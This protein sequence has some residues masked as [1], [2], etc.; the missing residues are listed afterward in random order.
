MVKSPSMVFFP[1]RGPAHLM[2][3]QNQHPRFSPSQSPLAARP[4]F[5]LWYPLRWLLP[6]PHT[7]SLRP[8]VCLSKDFTVKALGVASR[9]KTPIDVSLLLGERAWLTA[10]GR[11][12]YLVHIPY[13][14]EEMGNRSPIS[15][16]LYHRLKRFSSLPEFRLDQKSKMRLA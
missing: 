14:K 10:L 6:H 9:C 3:A 15:S 4:I 2:L 12:D 16:Y 11:M 1:M 5:Y 7:I 8:R 13:A